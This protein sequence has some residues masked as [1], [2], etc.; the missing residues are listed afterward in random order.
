MGDVEPAPKRLIICCDGTWQSSVSGKRN[1]PSN[2]A[3]LARAVAKV[4]VDDKGK[5]W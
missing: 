3:R 4:G 1:I 2:V 5:T